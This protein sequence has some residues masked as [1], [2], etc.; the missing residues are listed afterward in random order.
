[1]R[2]W[3]SRRGGLAR[4]EGMSDK[5]WL[6]TLLDQLADDIGADGDDKAHLGWSRE[7]R[8]A[9]DLIRRGKP[10]GLD[11]FLGLFDPVGRPSDQ[12]YPVPNP[13]TE[14]AFARTSTCAEAQRLASELRNEHKRE[15]SV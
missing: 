11:I 10:W 1:M 7:V 2:L 5:A 8:A 14:Q 6:E 13:F 3:R 12:P 9:A 15:Q 4:P